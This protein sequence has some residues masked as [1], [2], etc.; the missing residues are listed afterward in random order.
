MGKA[1]WIATDEEKIGI[2]AEEYDLL[3][4]PKDFECCLTEP[5]DRSWRRDGAEVIARLNEQDDEIAR[6]SEL[7]RELVGEDLEHDI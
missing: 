3:L 6:L 1:Y 2:C 7:L 5:E 4:G